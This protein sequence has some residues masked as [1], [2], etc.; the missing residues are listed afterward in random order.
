MSLY[1]LMFTLWW[2]NDVISITPSIT[3]HYSLKNTDTIDLL[4]LLFDMCQ[5]FV[6]DKQHAGHI[7]ACPKTLNYWFHFLDPCHV[8][9]VTQGLDQSGDGKMHW[10]MVHLNHWLQFLKSICGGAYQSECVHTQITLQHACAHIWFLP[11]TWPL[12]LYVM[13]SK[14]LATSLNLKPGTRVSALKKKERD[15]LYSFLG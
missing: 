4:V 9:L 14:L 12:L 15:I 11:L 13:M 3:I 1:K 8:T 2:Q 10:H 7:D 5:R 6:V